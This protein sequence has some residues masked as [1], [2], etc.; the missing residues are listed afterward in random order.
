[1]VRLYRTASDY[2]CYNTN[3]SVHEKTNNLGFGPGLTQIRLCSHRRLL[4]TANFGF[5]KKRNGIIRNKDTGRLRSY[6]ETD[7]SLCFCLCRLLVFPC[8][9]SVMSSESYYTGILVDL[10]I[11]CVLEQDTLTCHSSGE[12]PASVASPNMTAKLLTGML[13]NNQTNKQKLPFVIIMLILKSG[14]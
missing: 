5:R 7:L 8:C 11:C 9:G 1:M 2:A 3:K 13:T 4:E 14:W 12:Y 6:R 10:N